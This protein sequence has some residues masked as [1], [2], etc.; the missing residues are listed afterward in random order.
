MAPPNRYKVS[1]LGLLEQRSALENADQ[2][3]LEQ[4]QKTH[5]QYVDLL[6]QAVQEGGPSKRVA[7]TPVESDAK[8]SKTSE[9]A[10]VPSA[11]TQAVEP[12]IAAAQDTNMPLT[13]TGKEIASGGGNSVGQAEYTIERPLSIFAGRVNTYK[14]VHKFMTFGLAPNVLNLTQGTS[15]NFH[16]SEYLCTYLAEVPW[17]IPALYL[18]ESEFN[19]L[20][21]GARVESVSVEVYYR[22]STIQFETAATATG[23]AT[24]NQINDIAVA[25]ALNKTG[26]GSNVSYTAFGQAGQPMIP[27]GITRPKYD[28]VGT[29]YRGM[30]ADYYGTNNDVTQF[31]QYIPHH[32]L[33]RQTFL[34]NYWA[35]SARAAYTGTNEATR[36][37]GGWPLLADKIQQYDGKTVVNQCVLQAHYSP[38]LAPLKQPL[39]N[40]GH[41]L[42]MPVNGDGST[43]FT[44][45]VNGNLVD[46]RNASIQA[47]TPASA[48]GTTLNG[49]EQQSPVDNANNVVA[50]DP[51]FTIYSP[52][53]KSQIGRTGYWGEL[54]PHV[55][56]SIHIG[57][58]PVPALS[59]AS[60]II[61]NTGTGAWTDTRAYW[62]VVCTMNTKEHNPTAYPFATVA[63]VPIGDVMVWN[64]LADR[65]ALSKNPRDD[66]ATFGGLY[67][68]AAS[69]YP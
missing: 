41:G 54:I 60:S 33:A 28:V 47:S 35:L 17:H 62:E 40:V 5:P 61:N 48:S 32:Q 30:V 29:T 7:D 63:N 66:G 2:S 24:L 31:E 3:Y 44:V 16:I 67:T 14:K 21:P 25:H 46:M 59:T 26:Q 15:P 23:L 10:S 51:P 52:I 38:K 57:V 39:K 43:N 45:P 50:P 20:Q 12:E 37:F 11:G 6:D 1:S 27:T 4:I 64:E 18:N 58:Q 56:P 19:L 22:G 42:P 69:R 8:K 65:T 9:T 36:Q 49:S 53:E 13:G 55:Q 34:Y 68:T